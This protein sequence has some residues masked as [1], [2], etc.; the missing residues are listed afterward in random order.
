MDFIQ[1]RDIKIAHHVLLHCGRVVFV[2]A[3]NLSFKVVG[4]RKH[5]FFFEDF[6]VLSKWRL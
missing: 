3:C 5:E 1:S 4:T 2:D 6:L